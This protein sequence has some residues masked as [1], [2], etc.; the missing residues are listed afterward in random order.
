MVA[1]VF[2][3]GGGG[4]ETSLGVAGGIVHTIE[5]EDVAAG[6]MGTTLGTHRGLTKIASRALGT[7]VIKQPSARGSTAWARFLMAAQVTI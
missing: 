5:L 7:R 4:D 2:C 3:D 6:I 1:K